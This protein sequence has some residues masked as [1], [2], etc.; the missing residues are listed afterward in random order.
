MRI[1]RDVEALT[2]VSIPHDQGDV[3][4]VIDLVILALEG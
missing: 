1:K 3:K 2:G 4:P